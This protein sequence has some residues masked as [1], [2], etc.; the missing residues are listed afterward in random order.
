MSTGVALVHM[1]AE[2]R[3]TASDE[4]TQD[5]FLGRRGPVLTTIVIPVG[6]DHIGDLEL[7]SHGVG[8]RSAEDASVRRGEPVH[9]LGAVSVGAILGGAAIGVVV[10]HKLLGVGDRAPGTI[11]GNDGWTTAILAVVGADLAALYLRSRWGELTGKALEVTPA[12]VGGEAGLTAR[13]RF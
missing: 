12:I 9:N 2:S 13:I 3:R 8:L 7:R 6:T 5:F 10:G 4:M 11:L 1:S